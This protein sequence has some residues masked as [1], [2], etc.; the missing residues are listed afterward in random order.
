MEYMEDLPD[1]AKYYRDII[2]NYQGSIIVVDKT[3]KL[4]FCN[5][6]T[7]ELTS[8]TRDQLVG[9]TAYD[10]KRTKVFSE[11]SLINT[12]ESKKPSICYLVING[13]K[14][15]GVYAYSVPL[16]DESGEIKNVI[17]FSQGEAFSDEYFSRIESEKRHIKDMFKKVIIGNEDNQYIA[18]NPQMREIFNF[19]AQISKVD[20]NIII[21]GESG[22]GKEVLAKHI[23]NCSHRNKEIFIPV[24]CSAIPDDLI[25]SEMFGYEKGSFT[26]ASREGKP[27]LFEIAD[28]GTLFLDEIGDLPFHLQPKLLRVLET[29]EIRRIGGNRSRKLNVRIISATNKNLSDMVKNGT[30]RENLYYRLNTLPLTMLPLRQRQEDI[31]PMIEHFLKIYNK[32]FDMNVKMPKKCIDT[33]KNYSWPGNVREL[34]NIVERYV[35]TDGKAASSLYKSIVSLPDGTEANNTSEFLSEDDIPSYS[36]YMDKCEKEYLEKLLKAT[37]GNVLKISNITGLHISGIYR[38]FNRYGLIPKKYITKE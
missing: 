30:F 32:K 23:H 9:K 27:G 7:C 28:N 19:A 35:I 26:G 20:T 10:L 18:V 17:A 12:L 13:N 21:Y 3:G 22:T 11:S 37:N 25:E 15:R 4:V 38:K 2:Y 1:E 29:G 14:N 24:N 34:K 33:L 31:E 16:F 6:G 8:M 36:S 5:N